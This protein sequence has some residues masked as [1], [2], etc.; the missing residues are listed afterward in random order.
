M[1]VDQESSRYPIDGE[2]AEDISD[3]PETP[4][5][6]TDEI[7]DLIRNANSEVNETM[8]SPVD[9]VALRHVKLLLENEQN[10]SE[11]EKDFVRRFEETLEESEDLIDDEK[12]QFL[13]GFAS[14][15]GSMGLLIMGAKK[16]SEHSEDKDGIENLPYVEG[17]GLNLN[18]DL[19]FIE[20]LLEMRE[21]VDPNWAEILREKLKTQEGITRKIIDI[22]LGHHFNRYM[23]DLDNIEAPRFK[24]LLEILEQEAER[25]ESLGEEGYYK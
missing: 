20:T 7:G 4:K 24:L 16:S 10:L 5:D 13:E 19:A 9:K 25:R 2:A 3:E 12:V 15:F 6:S 14:N 11:M 22:T 1:A 17:K 8:S 18:T 23:K 21:S